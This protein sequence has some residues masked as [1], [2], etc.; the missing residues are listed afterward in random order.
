MYHYNIPAIEQKAEGFL[1][2]VIHSG[3]VQNSAFVSTRLMIT[4]T[5]AEKE[6]K[7]TTYSELISEL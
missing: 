1:S 4:N 5:A 3:D 6:T 7:V 2:V